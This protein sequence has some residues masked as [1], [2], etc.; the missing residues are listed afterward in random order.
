MEPSS[1]VASIGREV[2][3]YGWIAQRRSLGGCLFLDLRDREGLAQGVFQAGVRRS[4]RVVF[5][6]N[7]QP[8]DA[9]LCRADALLG[10]GR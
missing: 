1:S 2:V 7:A 9:S 5:Q 4:T 6:R 3:L 10:P 8:F